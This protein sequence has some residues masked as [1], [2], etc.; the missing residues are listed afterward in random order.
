M[1]PIL[2][3][4]VKPFRASR[5][6]KPFYVHPLTANTGRI[7]HVWGQRTL[8]NTQFGTNCGRLQQSSPS[9]SVSGTWRFFRSQYL[10]TYKMDLT[11]MLQRF[12]R[13]S[14]FW[15]QR[16]RFVL[17][18]CLKLTPQKVREIWHPDL[19]EGAHPLN[20]YRCENLQSEAKWSLASFLYGNV[21]EFP[22][23]AKAYQPRFAWYCKYGAN[24]MTYFPKM[25]VTSG[26]A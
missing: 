3:P 15:L 12:S 23:A 22:F 6:G 14:I 21:L 18:G 2:F 25:V 17:T 26:I 9:E 11:K 16:K 10:C 19:L 20:R 5:S 24:R 1:I 8:R 4:L 13:I 7:R